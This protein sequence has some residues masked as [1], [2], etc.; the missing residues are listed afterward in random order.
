MGLDLNCLVITSEYKK[1][2]IIKSDPKAAV[3]PR[4]LRMQ[5]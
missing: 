2:S 5:A 3:T 4:L 1:I